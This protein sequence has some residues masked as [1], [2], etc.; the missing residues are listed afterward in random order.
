ML[1]Q[2]NPFNLVTHILQ[3][4]TCFFVSVSVLLSPMYLDEF[5]LG[6]GS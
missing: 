4:R 2:L 3:M 1:V 6:L 5:Q